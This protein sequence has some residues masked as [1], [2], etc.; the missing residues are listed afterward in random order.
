VIDRL[1]RLRN[2]Q[3]LAGGFQQLTIL[4]TSGTHLFTRPA[5]KTT[6]DVSAECIGCIWQAAFSNGAHQIQPAARA[7]IF[8]ARD[9]V[10]WASFEAEP[11]VNAGKQFLFF[12]GESVLNLR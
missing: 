6:I 4:D 12:A 8:V 1:F 11:A 3:L 7:V 10:S 5:T 2:K 9:Y